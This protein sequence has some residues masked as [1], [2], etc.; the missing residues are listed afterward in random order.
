[1]VILVFSNLF[2]VI[3]PIYINMIYIHP[4][5]S[6][7]AI[8]TGSIQCYIDRDD[9]VITALKKVL[10]ALGYTVLIDNENPKQ[11]ELFNLKN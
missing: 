9:C 6:S 5:L 2:L 8:D 1:M 11:L 3:C 4:T 7:I 10:T